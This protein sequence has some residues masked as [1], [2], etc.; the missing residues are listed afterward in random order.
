MIVVLLNG[1]YPVLILIP[2]STFYAEYF[3]GIFS[4]SILFSFSNSN[5][6]HPE[7]PIVEMSKYDDGL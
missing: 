6:M 2:N 5:S 4:T 3:Y 7:S 1:T